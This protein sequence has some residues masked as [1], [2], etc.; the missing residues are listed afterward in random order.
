L[1]EYGRIFGSQLLDQL[2]S[3]LLMLLMQGLHVGR[4]RLLLLLLLLKHFGPQ[5]IHFLS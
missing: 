3:L 1:F 5:G 2:E 4:R